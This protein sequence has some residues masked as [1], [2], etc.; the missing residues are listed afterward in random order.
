DHEL[1]VAQRE[2]G[3]ED[4]LGGAAR[5]A[6]MVRRDARGGVAIPARVGATQVLGAFTL[7]FEIDH[8]GLPS[9]PGVRMRDG[10]Q[11]EWIV[12]GFSWIETGAALPADRVHSRG[13]SRGYLG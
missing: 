4:V 2:P 8:D 11:S 13:A 9:S 10:R 6:R 12:D 7:L 3:G 5:E 1:R